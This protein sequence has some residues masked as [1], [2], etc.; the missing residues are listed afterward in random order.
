M[1]P[2][3]TSQLLD[4]R[5]PLV[6]LNRTD[7]IRLGFT[8]ALFALAFSLFHFLGNTADA[9][10]WGRSAL[11][12]MVQRWQ[13]SGISM[14]SGDYSHGFLVPFASLYVVWT[15]RKELLLARKGINNFG[16]V[17]IVGSLLLH[18]LGVKSQ[19][20]RLSLFA[21]IGLLWSVPFYLYGWQ[22]AKRLLFPCAFL[23]FAVPLNFLDGLSGKLR[24]VNAEVSASVMRGLGLDV[25]AVGTGIFGP[26]YNQSATLRLDVADPC[27]GIRSLTA[28][29]ALTAIYGYLVMRGFWRKWALF[30]AG[31]PLAMAGNVFRIVIIGILSEAINTDIATGLPHDYAGF[32]VFGI[33]IS[34][35]VGVSVLLNKDFKEV[36]T[37]WRKN[38]ASARI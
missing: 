35:M 4:A 37:S 9:D 23:I 1:D 26:P 33:A 16:L 2:Q 10:R 25:K 28:M 38:L 31:I 12:W 11:V 30:L 21:L 5:Y 34:L 20:T 14:G 7:L 29:M 32:I 6:R 18:Y 13:D 27:S 15:Q 19:Q 22:V 36:I 8:A 24:L 17:F 3:K